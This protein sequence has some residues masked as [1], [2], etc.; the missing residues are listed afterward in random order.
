MKSNKAFT[1]IEL[2]VVVLIIG[3]LAAIAVPKYQYAVLKAQYSN[4]KTTATSIYR[5]VQSYI[6]ATGTFPSSI[7]VLDL[8]IP[9]ESR[10]IL[11]TAG[12]DIRCSDNSM[13]YI[14]DY[15]SNSRYCLAE[16]SLQNKLCYEETGHGYGGG[17]YGYPDRI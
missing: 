16:G 17:W 6:L 5:A 10:C 13:T 3:I 8:T 2:L 12:K 4:L 7:N 1:L 9:E 14:I 15:N 11:N